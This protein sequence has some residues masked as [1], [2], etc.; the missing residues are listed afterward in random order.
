MQYIYHYF[1]T[2]CIFQIHYLSDLHLSEANF[3]FV[4]CTFYAVYWYEISVIHQDDASGG[5]S[6]GGGGENSVLI[7]DPTMQMS[8]E[9]R[10]SH[11][12]LH[13]PLVVVHIRCGR[14]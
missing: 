9:I 12:I 6:G 11:G 3:C 13:P 7:P 8:C 2:F 5:D 14:A 10:E 1:H 4:E